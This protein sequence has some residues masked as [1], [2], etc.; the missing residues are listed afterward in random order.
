[1]LVSIVE[2]NVRKVR[3]PDER[4]SLTSVFDI[5]CTTRSLGHKAVPKCYTA[6]VIP[7]AWCFGTAFRIIPAGP[8]LLS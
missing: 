5:S 3:I 6:L 8:T 2:D 7:A 1:M 4:C